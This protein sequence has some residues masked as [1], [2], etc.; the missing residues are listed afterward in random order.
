MSAPVK[1]QRTL[2]LL[3]KAP[4]HA[5][6]AACLA[7]VA[8]GDALV[9]LEDGVLGLQHPLVRKQLDCG[10]SLYA[11]QADAEA[12]GL[13]KKALQVEGKKQVFDFCDMTKLVELTEIHPRIINW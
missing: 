10:F 6:F 7:T 11:V 4:G 12:R 9:L 1:P 8:E 2:H 5:R 3:N 13:M